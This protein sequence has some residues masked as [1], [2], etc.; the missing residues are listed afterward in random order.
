MIQMHE[1]SE[2][3]RNALLA[4]LT[5]RRGLTVD[6]HLGN[7]MRIKEEYWKNELQRVVA[8]VRTLAERGLAFRG[9]DE[10][11]GSPHNGNFLGILELIAEFDPFFENHIKQYGNSG[12][13][14]ISYLSKTICDE[15]VI[16]MSKKVR[17]SILNDLRNAG[18]F[19]L[20]VDSTPDLS[21]IDQLTVI[22]RYVSPD[23]GLPI[24]RFLT[25]LAQENHSG[26]YMANMV[27]EYLKECDVDFTKCRGQSYDNAANMSGR[28]NG[29]QQKIRERNKYAV[30]IPCAG[31]SLNLVGRAAVDCCLEAVNFFAIVQSLYTFFSGSTKRWAVLKSFLEPDSTVAKCLSDTRWEAHAKS[32]SAI[33]DGYESI[34][35][36][37]D[38]IHIDVNQKGDTRREAGILH[39]KMEELEFVFMLEFWNRILGQFHK[40]SKALQDPKILLST[41][42]KLYASLGSFLHDMR[43]HFDD[44]EQKSKDK[45]PGIDYKSVNK[46]KRKK[47]IQFNECQP[48]DADEALL[49]REKF[50]LKSFIPVI[51]ALE[52]NLKQRALAYDKIANIFSFLINL[53][54]SELQITENV[55]VL[56]KHYPEDVDDNLTRE[57]KHFHRYIKHSYYE[58]ER[59]D[60]N[61]LDL[62][63]IIRK[64]KVD[65]VF[66]NVETILRLFLSLM[67]TNCSGE[68]SFS[69]LKLIKNELRTTMLQEKLS[70]LSI[71]CLESDKLR[72]LTFND[73]I[74]DFAFQ[75]VRKKNITCINVNN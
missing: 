72:Q 28:Y 1:N 38:H 5:R 16:L 51:D 39:E 20:S 67:V 8:V 21:H 48:P 12:T 75:K 9:S 18:Y 65:I 34:I 30:Y 74:E 45:L 25:F 42:A 55:N 46:R 52:T 49:P 47:K 66:P 40:T 24:E 60:F 17:K 15:L 69:R 32:T 43:E 2:D 7:Q 56:L 68:R 61:H 37:L 26:E 73:I 36:A 10:K 41:C 35:D 63:Q 71:M 3:H 50:R 53:D 13:G 29:M 6:S 44:I 11:F 4:Y 19:S 54:I 14:N 70:A 31:H 59:R 57:I 62:Y 64:E 33:Y 27:L 23:D 58:S 22:I